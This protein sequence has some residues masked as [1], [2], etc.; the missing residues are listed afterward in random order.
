M[1]MQNT[2]PVNF[3]KIDEMT[4]GDADFR[5]ELVTAIFNSLLE[6]RDTYIEGASSENEDIIQEIRHKVKPSL[7]LFEVNVLNELLNEGKEIIEE[8][9]FGPEFLKHLD[10]FLDAVQDAI[11]YIEPH[12]PKTEE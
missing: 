5:A 8:N 9:G 2:P 7:A 4:A 10:N 11:D 3:D 12:V 6:L 1:S